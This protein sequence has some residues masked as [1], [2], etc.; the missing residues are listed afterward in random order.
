M[1]VWLNN[2][3]SGSVSLQVKNLLFY[4]AREFLLLKKHGYVTLTTTLAVS[5]KATKKICWFRIKISARWKAQLLNKYQY[6]INKYHYFKQDVWTMRRKYKPDIWGTIFYPF[7][8]TSNFKVIFILLARKSQGRCS[9]TTKFTL[10]M[11]LA[12]PVNQNLPPRIYL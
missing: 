1:P 3:P 4:L 2:F 10:N 12:P 8:H 6:F 11:I 9:K 5:Y 7:L